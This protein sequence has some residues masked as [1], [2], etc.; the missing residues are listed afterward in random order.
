MSI[1]QRLKLIDL[2]K[3]V[4]HDLTEG[5][6][7]GA[8]CIIVIYIYFIVSISCAV[9]MIM[10]FISSLSEYLSSVPA[11]QMLIDD[12]P[13]ETK[14]RVEYHILFNKVPCSLIYMDYQDV[15]GFSVVFYYKNL[16]PL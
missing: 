16:L 1:F 8:I 5:T 7:G 12:S 14:L 2:Y 13:S 15:L 10:L 3:K 9:I 4:P 6:Y 11:S